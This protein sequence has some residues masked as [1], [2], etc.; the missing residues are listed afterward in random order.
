MDI[1]DHNK[2]N[3]CKAAKLNA[4]YTF[5]NPCTGTE[6]GTIVFEQATGGKAPY[7]YG[8]SGKGF[9]KTATFEGLAKGNYELLIEDANGCKSEVLA[10]VTL[11]DINCG[12]GEAQ[13]NVFNP[14][15]EVWELANLKSLAGSVEVYN[16]RGILVYRSNFG[17]FE[18]IKWDG[19]SMQGEATAPGVYIYKV[20]YENSN[21][22][23][24]SVTVVY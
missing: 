21:V 10:R 12:D 11:I 16:S 22:Q 4:Q 3:P 2:V 14:A 24:G 1:A 8:I 19:S 23:Q 17:K 9:Q 13:S 6:N 15:H 5:I 20:Q 7:L 18:N